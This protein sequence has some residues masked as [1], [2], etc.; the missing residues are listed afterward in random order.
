[1]AGVCL[2]KDWLKLGD[3]EVASGE[4]TQCT[5]PCFVQERSLEVLLGKI[6]ACAA[7]SSV[8]A[9]LHTWTCSVSD[10]SGLEAAYTTQIYKQAS[11]VKFKYLLRFKASY[12]KIL[13]IQELQATVKRV[14][15]G[16]EDEL[17]VLEPQPNEPLSFT[18]TTSVHCRRELDL[19]VH[20]VL[21]LKAESPAP[22]DY[23]PPSTSVLFAKRQETGDLTLAATEGADGV[24]SCFPVHSAVLKLCCAYFQTALGDR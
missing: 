5:L 11:G 6:Y 1:M 23:R 18:F 3:C 7:S 10:S 15:R 22:S 9:P 17:L 13:L 20:F 8:D 2:L 14:R 19:R 24:R 16:T 12:G 21:L 4:G